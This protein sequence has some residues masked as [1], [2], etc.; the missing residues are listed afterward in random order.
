MWGGGGLG[1]TPYILNLHTRWTW[2]NTPHWIEL[3]VGP[4]IVLDVLGKRDL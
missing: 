4:K 1:I 3:L 2:T